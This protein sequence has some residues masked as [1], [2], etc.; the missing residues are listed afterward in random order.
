MNNKQ[1]ILS[2]R[3]NYFKKKC[4]ESLG[5]KIF[6][7]AYNYLSKVKKNKNVNVNNLEIRENLMNMFGRDNI[8]FWQLIEQILILEDILNDN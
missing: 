1:M 2:E 4:N 3:I 7:D 6:L 5:E 8:G